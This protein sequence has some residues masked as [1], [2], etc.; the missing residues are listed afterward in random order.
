MVVTRPF[1][2]ETILTSTAEFDSKCTI[3]CYPEKEQLEFIREYL[4]ELSRIRETKTPISEREVQNVYEECKWLGLVNIL[5][6]QVKL[7]YGYFLYQIVVSFAYVKS[8]QRSFLLGNF[9][10][11]SVI[12]VHLE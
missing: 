6:Y 12:G 10:E 5:F 3:M 2:R 1:L 11:E 9:I 8:H 4:V 7:V